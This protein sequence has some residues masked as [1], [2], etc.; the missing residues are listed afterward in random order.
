MVI[1]VALARVDVAEEL[2]QVGIVWLVV[3]PQRP[4]VV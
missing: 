3:K 1:F 2:A 4:H